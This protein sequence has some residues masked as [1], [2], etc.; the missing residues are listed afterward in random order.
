MQEVFSASYV[1]MR[2]DM[3]F[4]PERE[5]NSFLRDH[6]PKLADFNVF[7]NLGKKGFYLMHNLSQVKNEDALTW[8]IKY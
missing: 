1:P 2:E 7:A 4:F 6:Y 8:A 3:R 5:L